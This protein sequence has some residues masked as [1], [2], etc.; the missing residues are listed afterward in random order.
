MREHLVDHAGGD[1]EGAGVRVAA[2][3]VRLGADGGDE[4]REVLHGD[5]GERERGERGGGE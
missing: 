5:A 1:A 4:N 3:D 2:D